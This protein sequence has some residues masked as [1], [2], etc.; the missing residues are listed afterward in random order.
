MSISGS[1]EVGKQIAEAR[2]ARKW[3]RARLGQE[4]GASAGTVGKWENG[5]SLPLSDAVFRL[6]D[7]PIPTHVS[8]DDSRLGVYGPVVREIVNH[9][10]REAGER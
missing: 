9:V 5:E 3:N 1:A 6:L 2:T 7:I 10:R 4:V 8:F